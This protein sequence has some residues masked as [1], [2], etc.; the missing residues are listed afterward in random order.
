MAN[1]TTVLK[2]FA[3]NGNSRTYVTSAHTVAEPRVVIQKRKIPTNQVAGV[4]E[5]SCKV[6]YGT[7][8]ATGP[9]AQKISLEVVVRRPLN[10]D[11]TDLSGAIALFREMVASDNFSSV[12]SGQLWLQ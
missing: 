3:D 2:E 11:A 6:V 8:D 7:S 1:M 4:S 10:A 9:L 5:D 12:I